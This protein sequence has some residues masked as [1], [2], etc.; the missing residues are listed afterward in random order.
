MKLEV[1]NNLKE[2]IVSLK[3]CLIFVL[4]CQCFLKWSF[5]FHRGFEDNFRRIGGI[6]ITFY[7]IGY[8]KGWSS[9]NRG[10][11]TGNENF[12]EGSTQGNKG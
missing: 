5:I 1:A 4:E 11:R 12:E 3:F 7:L 6:E 10:N 9:L 2:F 8:F